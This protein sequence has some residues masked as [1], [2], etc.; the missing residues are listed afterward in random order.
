[1]GLGLDPEGACV[2]VP[3]SLPLRASPTSAEASAPVLFVVPEFIG[4]S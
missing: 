3:K 1:M 2:S 4:L